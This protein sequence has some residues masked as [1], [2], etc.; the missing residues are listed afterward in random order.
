[1][2]GTDTPSGLHDPVLLPHLL[3][4]GLERHDDR[5][6][7]HLGDK[8]ASYR[9][10]RE[11]ASQFSQALQS[12]G[13]GPGSPTAVL[14]LNRPEV[15]S[16]M[17]A[18]AVTGCRNTALHPLGSADDQAFVLEDAGIETLVFDPTAFEDRAREL[19]ERV[20]TLKNLL[21]LGPSEVGED[22]PALAATFEP[23][24][25]V[26]PELDPDGVGALVYTGGTTGRPKAVQSTYRGAVAMTMIQMQEWDWPAHIRFLVATPLS[27]AAGAVLAPTI[28]NGG[29]LYVLDQFS[30]DAFFDAV[31]EHRITATM[32]VPVMLYV[33]LDHPRADTADLSSLET[34]F[35]GASPMSPTRLEEAIGKWG[36]KFCQFYG[37]SEVP[38]VISTLRK[39]DHDPSVPGRLASAGRITPWAHVELLDDENQPVGA[40]EAGEICVRGPLVMGGYKDLPEQTAEAFAGGWMHT[41]DVGRIDEDGFLHIVDRKK[42]MI[43]SGGFN[44]FPSEVENVM[45]SHPAVAQ[46]AVIG[47]P[48]DTWGEAVKAVVVLRPGEDGGADLVAELQAMVKEAKGSV[49]APKTVDVTDAIPLSPLGKPDKKALRARYWE[50][51]ERSVG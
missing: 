49:Q 44:V 4:K 50:G 9:E 33:L 7:L 34:V 28:L 18:T 23:R 19:A 22:Y 5:P 2:S 43:V 6:C 46:V 20:P 51:R 3:I 16:N 36:R 21:A 40:G 42:D 15:L 39:A 13:V 35:Y 47:V 48:D 24:P 8:T 12:K 11:R 32:L 41:G 10:T 45:S 29:A 30:P 17:L 14:S 26:A 38:M 1:M 25:L 31:E 27:H 37:Q